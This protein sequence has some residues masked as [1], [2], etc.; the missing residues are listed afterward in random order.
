MVFHRDVEHA[1]P[2]FQRWHSKDP[3]FR[4]VRTGIFPTYAPSGNRLLCNNAPGAKLSTNIVAMNVDGSQQSVFFAGGEKSALGPVWSPAGDH[5]AFALGHFFPM[6][7]GPAIADIAVV[8]RDGS[9]LKILTDGSG[10][11]GFP[12][13]SPDGSQIVYRA[14]GK[15]RLGLLS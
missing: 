9:G 3:Q 8:S 4:L 7:L 1:W 15:G 14:S 6:Q 10:N 13:W 2:P 11:V 12:S 5:V